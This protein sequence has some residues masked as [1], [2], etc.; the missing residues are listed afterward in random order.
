MA[1]VD[2]E[3]LTVV[4]QD[5]DRERKLSMSRVCHGA[6]RAATTWAATDGEVTVSTSKPAHMPTTIFIILLPMFD[7]SYLCMVPEG[8]LECRNQLADE[9]AAS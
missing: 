7:Q 3:R 6:R 4:N 8:G 1:L 9:H 2:C 5:R